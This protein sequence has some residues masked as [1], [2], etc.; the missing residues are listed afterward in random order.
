MNVIEQIAN[1]E[2]TQRLEGGERIGAHELT[3]ICRGIVSERRSELLPDLDDWLVQAL[4]QAMRRTLRREAAAVA[5]S[6]GLQGTLPG[7]P[8][9]RALSVPKNGEVEYVGTLWAVFS[10]L[11]GHRDFLQ[12]KIGESQQRYDDWNQKLDVLRV[13][14]GRNPTMTLQ[15]ALHKLSRKL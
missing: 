6:D 7:F 2:L 13:L 8:L 9:P 15:E 10:D 4:R 14:M 1:E 3:D 12:I 11:L 5:Q